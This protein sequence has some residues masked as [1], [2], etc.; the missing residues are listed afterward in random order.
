MSKVQQAYKVLS[1]H[2][3]AQLVFH[4]KGQRITRQDFINL[5]NKF[6]QQ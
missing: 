6:K 5:S 1:G 3:P 4:W 2:Y